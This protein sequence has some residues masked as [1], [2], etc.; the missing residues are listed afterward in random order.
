MHTLKNWTPLPADLC[1]GCYDCLVKG[2]CRQNWLEHN[3]HFRH[4]R[5]DSH[6]LTKNRAY[7]SCAILFQR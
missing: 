1:Q 5:I 2:D 6:I 3:E 7:V 4:C